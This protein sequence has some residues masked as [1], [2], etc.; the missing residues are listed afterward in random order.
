[1]RASHKKRLARLVVPLDFAE[2]EAV[3]RRSTLRLFAELSAYVR[4]AMLRAGIDPNSAAS[5]CRL[6]AE[7]A[8][9]ADTAELQAADA[10]FE[11]AHPHPCHDEED[12]RE[13]LQA[14]VNRIIGRQFADGSL[15]DFARASFSELWAWTILQARL[16]K[17]AAPRTDSG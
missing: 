5:L 15:P 9:F 2:S 17:K 4:A 3:D 6:E 16:H 1:M 7:C 14:E 12:P 13:W 8:G 11:A 10:A